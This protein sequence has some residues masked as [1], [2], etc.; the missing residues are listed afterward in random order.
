LTTTRALPDVSR[1]TLFGIAGGTAALALATGPAQAL[2]GPAERGSADI[3]APAPGMTFLDRNENPYG[4]SPKAIRAIAEAASSGCYYANNGGGP[5]GEH[6]RR[7]VRADPDHVLIGSGST[8]VLNCATMGLTD[9][10][11]ILAPELFFD[12][13]VGYARKKGRTVVTVPM[14]AAMGIDLAATA[15]A[16]TADTR[17]VHICNPNNPTG[18]LIPPA[19]LRAFIRTVSPRA[20]VLVDEA[21]NELTSDPSAI[22]MVD[23]VKA[24]DNVLVVRTFSKVFGLAGLRVGYALGQPDT[25]AKMRPW[26]MS[27]GGNTAGIA[28]AIA[29]YDDEAFLTMSRSRILEARGIIEDAVRKAGLTALPSATNFVF[30][31]VPDAEAV[32]KGMEARNI[33]IRG[34]YSP[35]WSEWSRVST[36]RIEDVQRYARAL[37]EVVG[38]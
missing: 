3:F 4:P 22:S 18:I 34:P 36:G 12:P 25:I 2:N 14:D 16:V 17:L 10:G 11:H 27:I 15:A 35:R 1:R 20:T 31:K 30:V 8:E 7:T 21:Y 37:P 28:A 5:A 19:E 13:P 33:M 29:S 6:D 24:G 26:S 9:G 38:A 32:R 23:R